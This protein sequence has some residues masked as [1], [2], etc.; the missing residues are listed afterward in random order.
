MNEQGLV[1]VN[2]RVDSTVSGIS[3]NL[4]EINDIDAAMSLLAD[5]V[6]G[7]DSRVDSMEIAVAGHT[8]N[9]NNNTQSIVNLNAVIGS[10][11][12]STT[13]D[14]YGYAT[15]AE[16]IIVGYLW[17][18]I[19]PRLNLNYSHGLTVVN[20]VTIAQELVYGHS[21][22]VE[23]ATEDEYQ[24][25]VNAAILE[26]AAPTVVTLN[27]QPADVIVEFPA[28]DSTGTVESTD[29]DCTNDCMG[30]RVKGTIGVV[31]TVIGGVSGRMYAQ[32]AID[33]V[34]DP[35]WITIDHVYAYFSNAEGVW[36]ERNFDIQLAL[37]QGPHKYRFRGLLVMEYAPD[38]ARELTGAIH[39]DTVT[40]SGSGLIL[41]NDLQIKW[42]IEE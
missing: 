7:S 12:Q 20:P 3:Y 38:D 33:T 36:V 30:L 42:A 34:T 32:I 11:S 37:P 17:P 6:S 18:A 21:G 4:S 13:K 14:Q 23:T 28:G 41:S 35:E 15:D 2:A 1:S 8:A 29:T 27:W 22:V 39:I 19:P 16:T 26:Y 25:T 10:S 40:E 31:N 24:F 5:T 9:I